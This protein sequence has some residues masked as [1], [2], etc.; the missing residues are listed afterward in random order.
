[1]LTVLFVQGGELCGLII[2]Q[3]GNNA[4]EILVEQMVLISL[5][6]TWW[7]EKQEYPSSSPPYLH[8][9]VI[10]RWFMGFEFT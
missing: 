10:G 8:N 1:M 4:K 5:F 7:S 2:I 6:S 3:I 9:T